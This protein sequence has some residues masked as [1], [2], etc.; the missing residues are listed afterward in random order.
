M[1]E[2]GVKLMIMEEIRVIYNDGIQNDISMY[3]SGSM[4]YN[5]DSYNK[6]PTIICIFDEDITPWQ[7]LHGGMLVNQ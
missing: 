7:F 3:I 1:R 2:N 6:I 4:G 5:D